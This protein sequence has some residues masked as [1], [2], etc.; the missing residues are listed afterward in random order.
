MPPAK[1]RVIVNLTS[2]T[3]LGSPPATFDCPG[4][5]YLASPLM[6]TVLSARSASAPPSAF[7]ASL[8]R[9][10]TACA[11]A[12]CNWLIASSKAAEIVTV[13]LMQFLPF[14]YHLVG[15][16]LPKTAVLCTLPTEPMT[17]PPI[18]LASNSQ[19]C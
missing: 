3:C 10:F 4:S 5:Q 2:S 11:A 1:S 17:A 14:D 7:T 15:G 19:V 9:L 12:G 6:E 18:I 16:F 8:T 13:Y